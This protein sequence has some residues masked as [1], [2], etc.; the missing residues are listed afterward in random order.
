MLCRL[1]TDG[2]PLDRDSLKKEKKAGP[3]MNG[4]L[5]ARELLFLF[6]K[7]LKSF[8]RKVGDMGNCC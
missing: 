5:S 2:L 4:G 7:F 6:L 8:R 3:V 1:S